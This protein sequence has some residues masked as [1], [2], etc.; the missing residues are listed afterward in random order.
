MEL[1]MKKKKNIGKSLKNNLFLLKLA[2]KTSPGYMIYLIFETIK[3][4][5]LVFLEHTIGIYV[6]LNAVEY[7]KPFKDV[8]IVIGIIIYR[9]L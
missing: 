8:V 3:Q 5:G 2:F 1:T 6:V 4:E 9:F 7:H